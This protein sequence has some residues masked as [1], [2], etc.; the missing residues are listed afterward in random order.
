MKTWTKCRDNT[1][2]TAH[3]KEDTFHRSAECAFWRKSQFDLDAKY[4]DRVYDY[5]NG[6]NLQ[7][8]IS[9]CW[10]RGDDASYDIQCR[11]WDVFWFCRTSKETGERECFERDNSSE[12]LKLVD[13]SEKASLHY[14]W[15]K[16]D[17]Q[18]Y[19]YLKTTPASERAD[20]RRRGAMATPESF[21]EHM[22]RKEAA[23][24]AGWREMA[25]SRTQTPL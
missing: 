7:R 21:E 12:F 4:R 17:R 18:K 5:E 19:K 25:R 1:W 15:S 10:V 13:G 8:G 20:L 3:G 11:H 9:H 14:E 22:K 16:Y 6:T 24:V 23:A 2:D